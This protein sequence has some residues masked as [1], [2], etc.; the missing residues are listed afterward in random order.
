MNKMDTI[1]YSCTLR[2]LGWDD[3][4]LVI[5]RHFSERLWGMLHWQNSLQRER[6]VLA[7]PRCHSVHTFGMRYPLDIAF[8]SDVGKILSVR[9][10]VE[11]SSFATW[12]GAS[13]TLERITRKD[14]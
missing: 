6:I 13:A 11:P 8:I 10:A 2:M 12:R 14:I 4:T 9:M 1:D 3:A 7:F 5:A